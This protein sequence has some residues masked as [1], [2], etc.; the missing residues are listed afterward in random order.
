MDRNIDIVVDTCID[1][2]IGIEMW[3]FIASDIDLDACAGSAFY[4]YWHDT[5]I[6]NTSINTNAEIDVGIY[7]DDAE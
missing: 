2:G 6:T 1:T 5:A 7:A 3:I 4:S